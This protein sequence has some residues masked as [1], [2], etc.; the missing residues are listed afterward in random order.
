MSFRIKTLLLIIVSISIIFNT[1]NVNASAT[2]QETK[3]T[4]LHEVI[5][6][7]PSG[8]YKKDFTLT[9]SHPDNNVIIYYTLDGSE[10]DPNNLKGSTY[11][12]K[13]NYEQPPN[14]PKD[15]FLYHRYKTYQYSQPILIKDRTNEPDRISQI[16]TTTDKWPFYFPQPWGVYEVNKVINRINYF[17]NRVI[18][19]FHKITTGEITPI[20]TKTFIPLITTKNYSNKGTSVRAI[21]V[22]QEGIK[23]P[24][25]THTFFIWDKN[26]F[27]SPIIA[28]TAPEKN[29]FDYDEGIFVAGKDYDEWLITDPNWMITDIKA[30]ANW[31]RKGKRIKATLEQIDSNQSYP[32]LN[33]EIKIHGNSSRVNTDKN[34]RIYLKKNQSLVGFTPNGEDLKGLRFNFIIDGRESTNSTGIVFISDT[35][36]QRIVE[37]LSFGTQSSYGY[38]NIFLNGEYYG[39]RNIR[40]VKDTRYIRYFYHLPHKKKIQLLFNK[41]NNEISTTKRL[42]PILKGDFQEWKD[43]NQAFNQK[44]NQNI[45]F[46]QK[47]IDINSFIDYYVAEIFLANKDWPDNNYAFWKY[48]GKYN[49]NSSTSDGRY[50]WLI[51]DL[52]ATFKDINTNYLEKAIDIRTQ[53]Y[54]FTSIFR[55]LLNNLEFKEQF[56]TRFSDLMNTT[57]VPERM[58][59]IIENTKQEVEKDVPLHIKRW[60]SRNIN[61]W[62]SDVSNMVNFARERPAIQYQQLQDFFKLS[63]I[64]QL[65]VDVND[66]GFGSI[67]INTLH[68]GLKDNELTKPVAASHLPTLMEDVLAFPWQGK[69]FQDLPLKL[70]AIPK[71]GYQ[72]SYWQGEGLSQEQIIN[73]ILEL[74]PQSNIKLVA[75]FEKVN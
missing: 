43:L 67:K 63:S 58:V 49:Q 3:H 61:D 60:K 19:K 6:S 28:L 17:P 38:R 20:G 26:I 5:F 4:E 16:S 71:L 22:S 36:A 41:F 32:N 11:R 34:F 69:Y 52:D 24:I 35:T 57:F 47:Y 66:P 1:T 73:S 39:V 14:K 55:S 62:K 45:D 18:R 46:A 56:I 59:K 75:V 12:Y 15:N 42:P 13:N 50:R 9:L 2:L 7:Q 51:Y 68:L 21:A 48:L 64:Y 27:H 40:D 54:L 70:E 33:I 29:L 25:V 30:P 10:P 74:L 44:E 8:F 65:K 23:S 31:R 72:F 37:G 53:Q